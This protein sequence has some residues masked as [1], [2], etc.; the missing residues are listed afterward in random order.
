MT[1]MVERIAALLQADIASATPVSGGDLSD[2]LRL[3]LGD[4]SGAIAKIGPL[5]VCEA[6]MLRAIAGTGAPAPRVIAAEGDL[7]VMTELPS[8]GA[9]SD[10]WD[11]LAAAMRQ[12]HAPRED[13]YGW[14]VDYAFGRL[15]IPNAGSGDWRAFWADNRLRSALPHL[16]SDLA[17]RTER[18]AEALG[19]LLP[20]QPTPALLHGDLWGG[21]VLVAGGAVTGLIDPASY[22]G[23]REVDVAMLT[24]FD[25]PPARFLD[26]LDLAPGWRQRLPIYR[27]WPLLVH[28]RLFGHGYAASVS[29]TLTEIGF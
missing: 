4:G 17:R 21:N 20:A 6:E 3:R 23:D 10:A 19:E 1:D 15:A 13:A 27:L 5:A 9:L 16:P 28:L 25:H 8:A 12:L 14:H 24:L 29:S 26:S 22:I 11:S 7:L 2:V 18:V